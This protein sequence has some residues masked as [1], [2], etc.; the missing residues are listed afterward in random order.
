MREWLVVICF[1][2]FTENG[3]ATLKSFSVVLSTGLV[4]R[5]LPSYTKILNFKLEF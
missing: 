4:S 5:A 1:G 2:C 3:G